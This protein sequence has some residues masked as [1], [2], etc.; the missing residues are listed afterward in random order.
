MKLEKIKIVKQI[1]VEIKNIKS[2]KQKFKIGK[3]FYIKH[4]EKIFN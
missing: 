3:R 2:K 1:K 4:K